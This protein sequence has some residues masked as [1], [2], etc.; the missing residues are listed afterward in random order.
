[1]RRTVGCLWCAVLAVGVAVGI[2][3]RAPE[4]KTGAGPMPRITKLVE[5][6]TADPGVH[7]FRKPLRDERDRILR[8]LSTE[9]ER[10]AADLRTAAVSAEALTGSVPEGPTAAR[11]NTG[12][13]ET[14]LRQLAD[15]AHRGETAA[16]RSAHQVALAAYG[17]P[18]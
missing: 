16:I 13:L 10:M 11:P 3:C 9:C 7:R 1:M 2:G 15:A 4:P 14:A 12:A 18:K 8:Q 6:A 17:N 5:R